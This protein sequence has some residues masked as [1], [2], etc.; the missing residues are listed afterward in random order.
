MSYSVKLYKN[1]SDNNWI[2][3]SLTEKAT[4]D[5]NFKAPIDVEN[6][7]IYIN[8]SDSYDDVNYVYIAEFGRYYFAKCVGGTS[9]T[10]TYEC[11]SDPLMSFKSAILSSPAVIAR[12]PWHYDLYVHD[13]KLPVEG[14]SYRETITFKGTHAQIFNGNNNCYIL[15]TIGTGAGS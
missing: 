6:P 2:N 9:N 3:K 13:P 12:N 14:R 11:V 10:L 7:T 8:A 5:C 1:A 15:T 4:V